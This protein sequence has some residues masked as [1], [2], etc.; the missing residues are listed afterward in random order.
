MY[1]LLSVIIPVYNTEQYIKNALDSVL[2]NTYCNIKKV[3]VNDGSYGN[4][5]DIVSSYKENSKVKFVYHEKNKGLLLCYI[6]KSMPR[7]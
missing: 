7:T 3:V 2:K 4:F 6:I 1:K 5:E